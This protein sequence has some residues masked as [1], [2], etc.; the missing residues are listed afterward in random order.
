MKEFIK[1]VSLHEKN[2]LINN[3]C[4]TNYLIIYF[5]QHGVELA[6]IATKAP[7]RIE[8]FIQ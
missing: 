3:E 6:V 5:I 2:D 1:K 8:D 4:L 7:L